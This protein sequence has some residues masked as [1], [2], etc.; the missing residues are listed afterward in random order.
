[1]IIP[2]FW[3]EYKETRKILGKKKITVSRFGWS[4]TNQSDARVHAEKR[5]DEAFQ[6]LA[7]GSD[8]ERRE[9]RVSYNG[10]DGVPI[11]EEIIQF[12]GDAVL[13][14]N[15]YGSLC[16]NTPDVVFAD[17]DFGENYQN[18]IGP[19]FPWLLFVGGLMH[20]FFTPN[21]IYNFSWNVLG[22]ELQYVFV[23]YLNDI[24][25]GLLISGMSLVIVIYILNARSNMDDEQFLKE[26][27]TYHINLIQDFSKNYPDWNLR[28][29][30][31]PAGLRIMVMHDV[32]QP[33]DP[34]VED[35]FESLNTDY[36]YAMMCKRQN[37]FRAR[38]SPKPWRIG[39]EG[40]YVNLK[41]GVWPIAQNRMQERKDWVSRYDKMAENFASCRFEK[42]I[43]SNMVHDKCEKLRLVH[44]HYCK[45]GE[46]DLTLA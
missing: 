35:F 8:I 12:H 25:S 4:D 33:N 21:L 40:E 37:C 9:Q 6:Q 24:N 17:I 26:T 16:L 41:G 10:S 2:D 3:D 45:V 36:V 23:K 32:Y 27:Y 20:Y 14:R 11:R 39:L 43:G 5:V 44:D 28:V 22:Y 34:I 1:M 42:N 30:R 31:T 15:I 19:L 18:V 46:S 29:Y 7:D 13:S 38:V